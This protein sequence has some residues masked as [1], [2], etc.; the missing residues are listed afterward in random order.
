M[1]DKNNFETGIKSLKLLIRFHN[2][3]VDI[4]CKGEQLEVGTSIFITGGSVGNW[5]SMQLPGD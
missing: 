4:K 1:K 3:V 2:V 5:P